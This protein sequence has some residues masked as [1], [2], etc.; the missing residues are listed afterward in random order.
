MGFVLVSFISFG[1]RWE[2]GFGFG[3]GVGG[4]LGSDKEGL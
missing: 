2:L 4:G 3:G 1:M